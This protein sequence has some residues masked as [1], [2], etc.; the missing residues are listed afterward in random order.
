MAKNLVI[1]ESPAK[2]KTIGKFLGSNYKVKASVGHV[3][4]L[5][6]SKLG[7]DI[8]NE[9]EPQYITIRGKGP[10]INEIKKEAKKSDRIFL[11]TDPDREG[12]AISWHLANILKLDE[13]EACRI[14]FNEITKD[15]IKKA[16][17]TP[18]QIDT[19][20]VDAQQARRVLD[21]LVGYQI[22]PLLWDKVRKGLSAGRV[23]SA[24][25]KIICDREKEIDAFEPKEY[26][27]LDIT[28]AKEDGSK[29]EFK[30]HGDKENKIEINS[31]Q[32]TNNIIDA[33]N[34][35]ELD[36]SQVEKKERK[37]KAMPSFTTSSLQQEAASRLNFTTKKTMMVAQ[38]LYEGIDVKGEGNVGLV[39]YIRTDST[40]IS[41]EA[42]DKAKE[43]IVSEIGEKY[44]KGFEKSKS[45]A[46]KVQDAHEAIRPT[47][48]D[49]TPDSIK[50]SLSS[51]QYKLYKLIWERYTASLMK[52]SIYDGMSVLA[53][54]G[55][56]SFKATGSKLKFDGFLKVYSFAKQED[57]ILPDVS[58]GEKLSIVETMPKQHFTQP[59]PRYSEASLVKTLEELGIGRP[60]TYAPTISTILARGYVEKQGSALKPSELGVLI[61]E[62]MEKNFDY[63]VDVKFTADMESKL[64]LIEEG[65]LK[66]KSIISEFYGPLKVSIEKAEETIEKISMDEETD[67]ICD[68][69]GANML[70]KYGRFGRFLA[71]KN[72]PEC[73]ST[74]PLL[75]KTGLACPKCK[76]G[77]LVE[78]RSKRG[79]FFYGCSR[80]PECD[81]VSW[82]KPTGEMCPEC[83]E[84]L[85]EKYTK[86]ETKI[87]CSNKECGYVKTE[88]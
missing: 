1:V 69:C 62:I 41:D 6:K 75:N 48:I 40:R 38:Q 2:A 10:T 35:K 51:D 31:E 22:S 46:K 16:I 84:F 50:D 17:K 88:K 30:F 7:V 77:D 21:R 73:K 54:A 28:A 11:A 23:Q 64:D 39:T 61:N 20:L 52:D 63:I 43:Y 37:R 56:Y 78:R 29:I 34:N 53:D 44:F 33:I 36:I 42:V 67:E 9:F 32:E 60:S 68:K 81:F 15:A 47:Y 71:C 74:K 49:K 76:E 27:T 8:E 86:K 83:G 55:G 19:D 80:Y 59:P 18:R 57:T 65:K 5:P 70:I 14:E 3:R 58:V 87:K 24:V 66:W 25:T 4:D 13:K 72:Y 45:K 79:R 26:W 85:V 12:E 82:D